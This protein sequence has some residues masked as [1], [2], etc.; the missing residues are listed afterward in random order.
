MG[1]THKV[2]IKNSKMYKTLNSKII[3]RSIKLGAK[4]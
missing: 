4:L 1:Q 3:T 2:L